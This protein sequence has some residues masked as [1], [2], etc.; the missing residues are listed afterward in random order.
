MLNIHNNAV[1]Y[2]YTERKQMR[3]MIH[4]YEQGLY[5][6]TRKKG[7]MKHFTKPI[8]GGGQNIFR[9]K[10]IWILPMKFNKDRSLNMRL[11]PRLTSNELTLGWR[12]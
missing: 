9:K 6:R 8:W 1:R 4:Q 12:C 5:H 3:N 7:D 11:L 2:M 10:V